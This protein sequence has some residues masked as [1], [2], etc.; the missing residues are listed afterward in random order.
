MRLILHEER[1]RE[2]G[3]RR[4]ICHPLSILEQKYVTMR[5]RERERKRVSM[6]S[7]LFGTGHPRQG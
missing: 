2:W 4:A 1:E 5:K 7:W 3:K 6:Q